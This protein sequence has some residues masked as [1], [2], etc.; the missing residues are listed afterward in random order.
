MRMERIQ[1]KDFKG[2]ILHPGS[3]S[4]VGFDEDGRVL[5]LEIERDGEFCYE[6]PG[7]VREAGESF[8]EAARRETEEESGYTVRDME[9]LLHLKPSVGY[10]DEQI[11]VFTGTVEK[12]SEERE[13]QVRFV[14]LAEVRQL[15][16]ERKLLDSHSL[17]A[18][19]FA[20][21]K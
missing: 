20:L 1:R 11:H 19:L 17:A 12:V 13:F 8:E 18:L 6:L 14:D 2:F 4:C 15:A 21:E 9:F 16:R 3:A 7:G 10:T 5:L